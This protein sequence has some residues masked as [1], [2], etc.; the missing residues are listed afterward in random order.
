MGILGENQDKQKKY[1]K[2]DKNPNKPHWVFN[3][4]FSFNFLIYETGLWT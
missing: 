4:A 1:D 3:I 2:N